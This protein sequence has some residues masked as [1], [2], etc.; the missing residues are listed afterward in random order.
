MN[1][2]LL[3]KQFKNFL[4]LE[5]SLS[6]NSIEA[7]IHDIVKLRQFLDIS[8]SG[9][10]PAGISGSH[11]RDFLLFLNDLGLTPHSQ[12]RILSGI[13]AFYKFL[14]LEEVVSESP[15]A[16][17]EAPKLGRKLP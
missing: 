5:R 8:N 6:P 4:L 13:K 12:A 14:L 2:E 1:W 9:L 17:I 15:A 10:S 11:I 3:L 7:Y 16:L